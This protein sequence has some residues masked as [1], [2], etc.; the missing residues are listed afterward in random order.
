MCHNSLQPMV[1]IVGV[2]YILENNLQLFMS[3]SVTKLNQN[4]S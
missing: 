2:V 4:L 3:S 1:V